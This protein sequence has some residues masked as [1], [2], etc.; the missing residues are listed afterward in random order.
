[1]ADDAFVQNLAH[2]RA[3]RL[4]ASHLAAVELRTTSGGYDASVTEVLSDERIFVHALGEAVYGSKPYP[5]GLTAPLPNFIAILNLSGERLMVYS[6]SP[7]L[8]RKLCAHSSALHT[9]DLAAAL[10]QFE[11]FPK[12]TPSPDTPHFVLFVYSL[13]WQA[14]TAAGFWRL[15]ACK[16]TTLNEVKQGTSPDFGLID[17]ILSLSSSSANVFQAK[18]VLDPSDHSTPSGKEG[19]RLELVTAKQVSDFK[20]AYSAAC[21]DSAPPS[22]ALCRGRKRQQPPD[23]ADDTDAPAIARQGDGREQGAAHSAGHGGEERLQRHEGV[24]QGEEG[25]GG[26]AQG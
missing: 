20:D 22:K 9:L 4:L 18:P 1:M 26:Q 8:I 14:G 15:S 16:I 2:C 17:R 25:N 7:A 19:D 12:Q 13:P 24:A 21:L 11:E 6:Q 5:C 10:R 3:G 23:D